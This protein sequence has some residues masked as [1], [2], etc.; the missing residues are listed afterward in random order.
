MEKNIISVREIQRN[1]RK[2]ID[3]VKETGQPVYLTSHSQTEAVLLDTN[4]YEQL[5]NKAY[6]QGEDWA[7][8][9]KTLKWIR[10]GKGKEINLGEFIHA[11]RKNH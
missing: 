1:Y 3:Q 5:R 6:R 8:V 7:T 11:D 2:V 4:S 9:K 10:S